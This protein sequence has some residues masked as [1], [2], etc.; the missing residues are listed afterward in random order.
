MNSDGP[1]IG[2]VPSQ[3]TSR[4]VRVQS[5]DRLLVYTDGVLEAA[6]RGGAFFGDE[7]FHAVIA[8]NATKSGTELGGA[9]V[10]DMSHW[11]EN[12]AGFGDDVTLA[13]IEVE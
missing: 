11:C 2:L 1:L 7:R 5:G 9:I 8:Q 6:N 13:V 10:D 4:T 3:Y 12:A